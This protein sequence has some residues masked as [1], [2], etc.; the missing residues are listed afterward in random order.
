MISAL[1]L[2]LPDFSEGFALECDASGCGI[3]AVL[4]QKGK[5]IAFLSK[6]LSPKNQQLSAY[7]RELI[8]IMFAVSKWRHYLEQGQFIIKTDHESIK[9][10]LEQRLNTYV[11]QK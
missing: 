5:P 4:M 8:A 2:A 7:E 9:H 11:Q 6:P 1:V 3:G 10:L